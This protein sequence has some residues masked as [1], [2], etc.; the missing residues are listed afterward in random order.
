MFVGGYKNKVRTGNI[1]VSW[2]S[3]ISVY[4]VTAVG[5][6]VDEALVDIGMDSIKKI[7]WILIVRQPV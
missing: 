6:P 7:T 1:Q 3:E 4:V 5:V 2:Y